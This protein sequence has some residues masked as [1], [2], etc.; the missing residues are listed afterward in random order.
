MPLTTKLSTQTNT[1]LVELVYDG[2]GV[3]PLNYS[4]DVQRSSGT[5]NVQRWSPSTGATKTSG[6]VIWNRSF[7]QAGTRIHEVEFDPG[8]LGV[9][10]I[11]LAGDQSDYKV[12]GEMRVPTDELTDTQGAP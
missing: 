5:E 2:V 9:R 11:V 3:T 1:V 10:I 7:S 8:G 4:V 12:V 6:R